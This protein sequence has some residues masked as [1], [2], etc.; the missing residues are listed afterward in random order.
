MNY[1]YV[2]RS[3]KDNQLYVGCTSDL[4]NRL[5]K[6]NNGEVTSTKYRRPLEMIYYEAFISKEDAFAR[7][8]W[9]KTGWGRNHLQ[10][11]LDRTLKS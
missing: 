4:R 3:H 2:L 11:T 10:K 9:L 8:K 5:N 6:H 1:V 7:E